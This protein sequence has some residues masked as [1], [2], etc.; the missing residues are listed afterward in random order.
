MNEEPDEI[1]ERPDPEKLLKAIKN[2]EQKSKRGRLKIFLG[3]AAG[4]GKTYAMLE[5]AQRLRRLGVNVIIGTVNTHGR[6]ETARLLEGLK[7][8]PEKWIKYKETVFEELDID[9]ILRL[10]PQI[11]IIDEL[12]HS[13]V[14]GSRHP[15]RWQDVL[16][17]LDN[18]I[19]VFAT[20]NVQHI[21]SLNDV[22]E[23]IAGVTVR[24][25][26]PDQIIEA[27][28][29]IELV[30][31]TPEELLQRLKEGKVYLGEQSQIAAQ[32]FFQED[33]L[34]ALREIVMRYAAEKVDH[35]LHD[36]VSTV[37]RGTGWTPRERL[38][39]AISK[40]PHSQKLIRTTRRL[41]YTLD[42]PWIAVHIDDGHH[43]NEKEKATLA[44][45]LALAR[46]L[47]AEVITTNGSN[48]A[49]AI[50]RI[51]RQ[52]G[53]TQIIIGRPPVNRIWDFFNR[54]SLLDQLA[55]KCGD[56][57]IH[58]IRQRAFERSFRFN[59]EGLSF[60]Q[61][62]TSYFIVSIFVLLLTLF[63]S[64]ALTYVGYK[65]VG[66]IF[67]LGILF[68]SL[69]FRE[70]PVIFASLLYA[71]IWKFF[72]IP[73][74]G[75]SGFKEDDA[76]LGLYLFTG[77]FVGMLTDRGRKQ[78]EMLLKREETAQAL[79]EIARD[80]SSSPSSKQILKSVN[81]KLDII[82]EGKCEI[83]LKMM[84]NGLLFNETETLVKDEKE[85]A[86]ANW[87]FENDKEAGWSTS[88]LPV[89]KNLYLPL[90]GFHEVVGVL[91]YHPKEG[92]ELTIEE[93]NFLYTVGQLLANHI[94]RS[95]S[96]ERQRRM[97]HLNQIEKVYQSIL[98]LLS[99]QF[100]TPINTIRD[101]VK[102]LKTEEIFK[103]TRTGSKFI[104][105]IENSSEGLI[106]VIENISAMAKL[107]A[108]LIPMKKQKHDIKELLNV[109]EKNV[110][111]HITVH[112]LSIVIQ[113]D[114]PP[115]H[116]DFSL[117]EILVCNLIFN[118]IENSPPHSTIE[119][120]A[121]QWDHHLVIAVSDEGKGIPEEMLEAVF[122]KFY[123][124]PGTTSVGLGLGLSI[125]KTIA[126]IH[127]GKLKAENRPTGG[128]RFSLFLPIIIYNWDMNNGV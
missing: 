40:S 88:T 108:G 128:S 95:F 2:E 105:R 12:A 119:I 118:A 20:L 60:P 21:E 74:D 127:G 45:N 36:M 5:N 28:T 33:R 121:K 10:K 3:M 56:I 114:L 16:E 94:E 106:R 78:R 73:I 116:F 31:I 59:W 110:Q 43:L 18:G 112:K 41:A 57:D 1:D 13:N 42:A 49:Q 100:Q 126:E 52:R 30:D 37:E 70:G 63:N 27:A 25:T 71:L 8:I 38:L 46:D 124:L 66:F 90:K 85:R 26:V 67:L 115:L 102:Q 44:K 34:T 48:I 53:I 68:L 81:N 50:E 123:R 79:Y 92:K 32:H 98:N 72:F 35:D 109:C 76:L 7:I 120:E 17:I 97:E 24:E 15:K 65:V 22:V 101:A 96:E 93:K 107:S 62:G 122:E 23:N 6:D 29:Y 51:A 14:P 55:S 111:K 54:Y 99:N 64:A 89:S 80:I 113:D 11:V 125:A 75:S 9:E 91:T 4:V 19:D 83:I 39:V 86:A 104:Y 87:V 82:L 61:Q 84:D 58:V 47:G 103:E 77:I 69:F 117:I